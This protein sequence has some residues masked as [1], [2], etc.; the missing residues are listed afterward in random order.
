MNA[1][2]M[3]RSGSGAGNRGANGGRK[4]LDLLMRSLGRGEDGIGSGRG[5]VLG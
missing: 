1:M 3:T 4:R 2:I 5:G